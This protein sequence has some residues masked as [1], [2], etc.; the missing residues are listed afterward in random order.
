MR[1][2]S[3]KHARLLSSKP[4]EL[5]QPHPVQE[6]LMLRG[7]MSVRLLPPRL[8]KA[9]LSVRIRNSQQST[10]SMTHRK[11]NHNKNK[12]K[13][14]SPPR[15]A[16]RLKSQERSLHRRMMVMTGLPRQNSVP[17]KVNSSRES[18]R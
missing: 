8:Q 16:K 18:Y 14:N 1:Q 4:R 11:K 2:I 12:N 5:P 7:L 6:E 10:V 17:G 9:K 15:P 13:N 3:R